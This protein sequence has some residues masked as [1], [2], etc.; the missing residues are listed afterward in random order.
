MRLDE[1]FNTNDAS[2]PTPVPLAGPLT[3]AH[4]HKL[5]H[6]VSSFLSSCPS[7]L[8]LGDMCTL[9][10]IRNQ[11]EDRKG[12]GLA[13]TGFGLQNWPNLRGSPWLHTDS[14]WDVLIL[15]GEIMKCT[16]QRI[17]PHMQIASDSL[18]QSI[19]SCLFLPKGATTP[20]FSTYS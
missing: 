13:L 12:K 3:C 14:N 5:N 16:V 1:D 8:D 17:Q 18:Q 4:A 11:G 2:T 15:G 20:N 7:C 19:S 10:V 9:V 6:L